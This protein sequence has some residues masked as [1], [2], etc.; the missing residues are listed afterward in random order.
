MWEGQEDKASNYLVLMTQS[1]RF[2]WVKSRNVTDFFKLC[3]RVAWGG[4]GRKGVV[5]AWNIG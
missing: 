4:E 3:Y 1:L 5:L 2:T